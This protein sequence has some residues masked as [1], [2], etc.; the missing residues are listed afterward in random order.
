MGRCPVWVRVPPPPPVKALRKTAPFST[1]YATGVMKKMYHWR[2]K[3]DSKGTLVIVHG[4][5]EH[6]GRYKNLA[7]VFNGAGYDVVSADLPG[8]GKTSGPRGHIRRFEDFYSVVDEMIHAS[9]HPVYLMGHSL[10]GL[11]AL[12]YVEERSPGVKKLILSNPALKIAINPVLKLAL[13][14]LNVL[15][16]KMSFDNRINVDFLSRNKEAV[17]RYVEDELVHRQVTARLVCQLMEHLHKAFAEASR[18]G[19]PT[20]LILSTA[21]K[22]VPPDASERF[23]KLLQA[24][25]K[26]VK[27][28]GCYHEPFEDPEY[29]QRVMEDILEF[30]EGDGVE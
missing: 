16:P 12:R 26:L 14:F 19:I 30:L 2:A 13:A 4:L 1:Q 25:K 11:I 10:G 28:E 3:K 20:L 29:G 24:P 27:Y 5:G 9:Q 17:R 22:I 15:A 18:V 6:A 21:D 23:F 8:H 7:G